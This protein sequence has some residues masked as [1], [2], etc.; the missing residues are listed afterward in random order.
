MADTFDYDTQGDVSSMLDTFKGC[1]Q[2]KELDISGIRLPKITNKD[3]FHKLFSSASITKLN[4]S[5]AEM[6]GMSSFENMF[7]GK[8][9]Y[10]DIDFSDVKAGSA[11]VSTKGMFQAC[12][13]LVNCKVNS[14]GTDTFKT[15]TADQMFSGCT[16]LKTAEVNGLIAEP[17]ESLRQMF[18]NCKALESFTFTSDVQLTGVLTTEQMFDGAGIGSINLTD[19]KLPNCTNCSGMF[20]GCTKLETISMSGF[21]TPSCENMSSMF[22]NCV[23][24]TGIINLRGWDT[25]SVTTMESM[26]ENFA[27]TYNTRTGTGDAYLDISSFDFLNVLSC[28]QMFNL[29][30]NT[31][32]DYLKQV[33]L[34]ENCQATSLQTTNRMFRNRTSLESIVNLD[35]FVTDGDLNITTSMFADCRAMEVID[36]SSMNLSGVR[37]AKYMFNTADNQGKKLTT[38][39]VSANPEYAFNPNKLSTGNSSNMFQNRLNLKG[40]NGTTYNSSFLDVRYARIDEGPNS[41]KPGYFSVK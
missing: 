14:T 21:E 24:A 23:S 30:K 37:D 4:M 16:K 9:I 40:G 22:K 15:S 20:Q 13:N 2:L 6:I 38:I 35:S 8:T 34:P 10:T 36:I 17:C 32:K 41:A 1:G 28:N 7:N 31:Y 5:R 25:S 11:S 19:V 39:Y 26:F 33:T 18:F 3:S 12:T 29:D 27:S